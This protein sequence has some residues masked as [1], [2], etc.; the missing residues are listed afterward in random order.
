MSFPAGT[1][2]AEVAAMQ[3]KISEMDASQLNDAL[4]NAPGGMRFTVNSIAVAPAST[5]A[6]ASPAPTA[7]TTTPTGIAA[8]DAVSTDILPIIA[9]AGG[10]LV[11]VL[12]V[13]GV[14]VMRHARHAKETEMVH[15]GSTLASA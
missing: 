8:G 15:R 10:G 3:S 9:G 13:A 2:A 5:P 11:V 1:S 14:C 4:K 7:P 6:P 12:V